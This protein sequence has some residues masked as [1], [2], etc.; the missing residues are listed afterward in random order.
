M[1]DLATVTGQLAADGGT[2]YGARHGGYVAPV[3]DA[4]ADDCTHSTTHDGGAGTIA[5]TTVANTLF[6]AVL[7]RNA[8]ADAVMNGFDA[9]HSGAITVVTAAVM[10]AVVVIVV[11]TVAAIV[12]VAVT[13]LRAKR[14]SCQGQCHNTCKD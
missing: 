8:V 1:A 12:V 6:P 9:H 11:A 7:H 4:I 5:A 10:V 14:G 2:G 13:G 3:T